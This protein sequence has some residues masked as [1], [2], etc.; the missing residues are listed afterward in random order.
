MKTQL[1][2]GKENEPATNLFVVGNFI[3]LVDTEKGRELV[4]KK[5][6]IFVQGQNIVAGE[7]R[8][9]FISAK[10]AL[11]AILRGTEDDYLKAFQH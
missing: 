1:N 6:E 9:H 10:A 2:H 11:D 4:Q 3:D 5:I 7:N 8:V